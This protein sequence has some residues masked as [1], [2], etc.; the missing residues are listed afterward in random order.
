MG[1]HI[2][3]L[4]PSKAQILLGLTSTL[5]GLSAGTPP[6]NPSNLF[7]P[8]RRFHD[9]NTGLRAICTNPFNPTNN[10]VWQSFV[11]AGGLDAHV[12]S[13]MKIVSACKPPFITVSHARS[14]QLIVSAREGDDADED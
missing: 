14:A 7:T 2:F 9:Q 1:I 4:T 12:L 10:Q 3:H 5:N 8:I 13:G 11:Q 6:P